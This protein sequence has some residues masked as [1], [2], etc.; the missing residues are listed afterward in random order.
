METLSVVLK[1]HSEEVGVNWIEKGL[2]QSDLG[3][4]TNGLVNENTCVTQYIQ[5]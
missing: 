4:S 2:Y 5:D 1:E 3:G